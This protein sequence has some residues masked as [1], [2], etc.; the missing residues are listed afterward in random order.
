M[1][2]CW[3]Y[4]LGLWLGFFS[5]LYSYPCILRFGILIVSQNSLL[6]WAR[7]FLDLTF[8]LTE[9]STSSI[10]SS[11]LSS[12]LYILLVMVV[13][14]VS[15]WV[16]TFFFVSRF[17][18]LLSL[19]PILG[20]EDFVHFLPLFIVFSQIY[21]RDLFIS[22]LRICIIFIK[23]MLKSFLLWFSDV[24]IFRSAV[25]GLLDSIVDTLS[26]LLLIVS[27]Q[28]HLGI[29]VLDNCNYRWRYLIL[30]LLGRCF[31][32]FISVSLSDS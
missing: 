4:F 1:W 6:F 25:L 28:W 27:S 5:F 13:S 2:F 3:K 7:S 24:G 26:Q 22:C 14:E 20:L 11:L 32:P 30:F 17:H 10:V 23:V 15:V 31:F 18:S 12:I 19:F 16:C 21:L 8:S 29:C 9:I